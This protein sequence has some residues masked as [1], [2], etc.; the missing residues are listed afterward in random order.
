MDFEEALKELKSGKHI[1][2]TDWNGEGMHIAVMHPAD[3]N[4]MDIPYIYMQNTDGKCVPW[5]ASQ[6]D[7]FSDGWEVME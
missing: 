3:F 7:L 6:E 1:T 4:N 2:K 5:L